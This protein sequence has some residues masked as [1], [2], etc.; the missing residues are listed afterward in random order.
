M[1]KRISKKAT[2]AKQIIGDQ[3]YDITEAIAVLQKASFENFDSTFSISLDMNLDVRK[4]DQQLRGSIVLPAGTG[5]SI[6]VLAIAEG[7][8]ADAAKAAGADIVDDIRIMDKVK[9]EN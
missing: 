8:D 9:G 3:S 6:K 5:K 2:E 7:A 4:A 1:A